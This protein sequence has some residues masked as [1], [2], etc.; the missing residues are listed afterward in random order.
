MSRLD[1]FILRVTAQRALL[2]DVIQRLNQQVD[3][4]PGIVCE[5][6]L[7]NGR[8]YDH[9]REKVLS[10]RIVVFER[11][12]CPDERSRPPAQD[13]IVGR[14]EE[15]AP[16][17]ARAHGRSAVLVHADLGNGTRT[18]DERLAAWL[19]DVCLELGRPGAVVLTSTELRHPSLAE[20]PVPAD[21]AA[22]GVYRAYRVG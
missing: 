14:I 7:G 8:T 2:D 6:G 5:L 10:R 16:D 11:D 22:G 12:P 1:R 9:M 13:L 18:Y 3:T 4:M 17:F 19:P 15:T 21:V 20:L